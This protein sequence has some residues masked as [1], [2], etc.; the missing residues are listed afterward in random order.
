MA[1]KEVLKK[2]KDILHIEDDAIECWFPTGKNTVRVRSSTYGEFVFTYKN[3][4]TWKM[5]STE[6]YLNSLMFDQSR[7]RRTVV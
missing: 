5:E 3:K 2:A 7:S 1:P 4:K 6:S